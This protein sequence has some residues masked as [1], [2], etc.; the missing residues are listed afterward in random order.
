MSCKGWVILAIVVSIADTLMGQ[1]STSFT[2]RP[3]MRF[4]F[5]VGADRCTPSVSLRPRSGPPT[6]A[7]SIVGVSPVPEP[8]FSFGMLYEQEFTKR[9]A[10]RFMPSLNFFAAALDYDY[11]DGTTQR[12][13]WDSMELGL[14]VQAVGLT[15]ANGRGPCLAIGP[16]L[17]YDLDKEA[18]FN[19]SRFSIDAAVGFRMKV[20]Y[21]YMAPELRY[22]YSLT[23]LV[24]DESSIH[25]QVIDE[26]RGHVLSL[27]IVFQD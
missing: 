9:L 15:S 7:D 24:T 20:V 13:A 1:D 10:F 27:A 23:D 22:S 4:G 21:F 5:F 8:S 16:T 19:R 26:L 14:S 25:T 17:K 2:G 18:T 3:N 6:T 12:K 11:S